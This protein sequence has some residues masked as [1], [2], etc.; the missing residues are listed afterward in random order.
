MSRILYLAWQYATYYRTK[1]IIL[2]MSLT[3]TFVLPLT[4]HLLIRQYGDALR[5]RARATPLVLGAHGKRFDLVLKAL[6]FNTPRVDPVY[7][8]EV[9][10][11]RDGDRATP[12]PLQ[13]DFTAQGH[14][15]VGTTLAYFEYR[16]LSIARGHLPQRL[17]QAVLG[18]N[19]AAEMGL[20]PGD[21]LFSDQRSLYDI[22]RTYPL[23]MQVVGV[24]A[25]T[26]SPDD[27]AVFVD[28]KTT[29]II[30]GLTHGHQDVVREANDAVILQR[31]E[32]EVITNASI[33]E[34]NEVT[35][36]NIDSFHTHAPADE[37]P[38]SAIIVQPRDAKAATILKARYNT[39]PHERYRLLVPT[40]VIDDLLGVVF[41]VQRFFNASFG[42]VVVSVVL[43]LSLVMLLS[44]RLRERELETMYKLGCS[45]RATA[46][47]QATELG[48][49]LGMSLIL[50][51][52]TAGLVVWLAPRLVHLL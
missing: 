34:Y 23:K 9:E 11:L 10:A 19:V 18:A 28:V 27:R 30:A 12:I 4:A 16:G 15:I 46:L 24:L 21:A 33:F 1:T 3:L 52:A 35:D 50:S 7:L 31:T 37:L 42:L 29:W 44:R 32:K 17:G 51:T 48:L 2:V 43:L 39:T 5:A 38:L 14:P 47:L 40:E 49:V 26:D 6:Y 36:A 13:L 25:P 45:R 8:A 22:T 41:R 20:G